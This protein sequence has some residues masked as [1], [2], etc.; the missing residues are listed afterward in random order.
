M[1]QPPDKS[2]YDYL[3]S[4]MRDV[5]EF[6]YAPPAYLTRPHP[7]VPGEMLSKL[8]DFYELFYRHVDDWLKGR[9]S[10]DAMLHTTYD[11]ISNEIA[12]IEHL[13]G[14]AKN[15]EATREPAVAN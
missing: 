5:E 10:T 2:L 13:I 3:D 8:F 12:E 4:V 9:M 1:A 11:T 14:L 15:I 6:L 7:L